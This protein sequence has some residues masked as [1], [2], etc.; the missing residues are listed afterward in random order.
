MSIRPR[1]GVEV[2]ELTARVA[3]AGNPAGTTAMWVRDRLDGLW[4]DEDFACGLSR[5]ND[6]PAL[7]SQAYLPSCNRQVTSTSIHMAKPGPASVPRGHAP[8]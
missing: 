6:F 5:L 4:A 8:L 1:L 3:R 2:P 7:W